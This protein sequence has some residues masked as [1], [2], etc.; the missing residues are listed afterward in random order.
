[1]AGVQK[2]PHSSTGGQPGEESWDWASSSAAAV[3]GWPGAGVLWSTWLSMAKEVTHTSKRINFSGLGQWQCPDL[4]L[5]DHPGERV[6]K[7]TAEMLPTAKTGAA[8]PLVRWSRGP[9]GR[10]RCMAAYGRAGGRA[11][12]S[13]HSS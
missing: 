12:L 5:Q 3:L 1:M 2:S 10:S 6:T 9:G 4:A 13:C 11:L 8:L 7:G